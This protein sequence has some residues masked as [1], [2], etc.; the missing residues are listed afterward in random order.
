MVRTVLRNLHRHM[1]L[2]KHYGKTTLLHP[3]WHQR[4]RENQS[5]VL[6]VKNWTSIWD[7]I[8]ST[9][10]ASPPCLNDRTRRD[11]MP[12]LVRDRLSSTREGKFWCKVCLHPHLEH[13]RMIP[14]GE[15]KK[16]SHGCECRFGCFFFFFPPSVTD[17]S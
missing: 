6:V 14:M 13:R 7:A 17:G 3:E 2:G 4:K 1:E 15:K 9:P 16:K 12:A 5:K 8:R 10:G 11:K